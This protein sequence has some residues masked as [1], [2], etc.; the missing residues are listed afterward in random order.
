MNSEDSNTLTVIN[1]FKNNYIK[2]I[3]FI[4]VTLFLTS[5]LSHKYYKDNDQYS[6]SVKIRVNGSAKWNL[7]DFTNPHLDVLYFLEK[8]DFKDV[9]LIQRSH[10]NNIIQIKIPH[11]SL[12]KNNNEDV[13]KLKKIME[14]YKQ[15]IIER[16]NYHTDNIEKKLKD[17]VLKSKSEIIQQSYNLKIDHL[18]QKRETLFFHLENKILYNFEY[19][20]KIDIIKAKRKMAKNLVISLMLSIILIILS[21]WIKLFI[22]EIK[23]NS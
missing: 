11:K 18:L 5:V 21:L 16:V 2:M 8:T 1:Y 14:E 7:G 4:S 9:K 22:R 12:D 13:K 19:D 23:K 15:S 6:S 3:V 20:G 10:S 17:R